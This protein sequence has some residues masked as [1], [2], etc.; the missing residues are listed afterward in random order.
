MGMS[1]GSLCFA[2]AGGV[3]LCNGC[4]MDGVMLD[5]ISNGYLC[6]LRNATII[7]KNY[8]NSDMKTLKEFRV[9]KRPIGKKK[10]SA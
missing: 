4:R 3:L 10:N 5:T 7:M 6:I 1:F 9:K 8:N 2:V